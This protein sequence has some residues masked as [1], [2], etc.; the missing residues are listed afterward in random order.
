MALSGSARAKPPRLWAIASGGQLAIS[1][2]G[3]GD[4]KEGL[5]VAEE[6]AE[7]AE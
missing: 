6:V 4:G 2:G 3:G 1:R 7:M 5:Q